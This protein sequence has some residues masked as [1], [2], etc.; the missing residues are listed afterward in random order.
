[1]QHSRAGADFFHQDISV[2]HI[3]VAAVPLPLYSDVF[4]LCCRSIEEARIL[5]GQYAYRLAYNALSAVLP[6]R[7]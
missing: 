6:R 1:V 3:S 5:G 4:P 2:V 7:I